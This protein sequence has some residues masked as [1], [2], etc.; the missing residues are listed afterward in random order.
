MVMESV[1]LT[2]Y[3]EEDRANLTAKLRE[4]RRILDIL[5]QKRSEAQVEL[6]NLA[7]KALEVGAAP[8]LIEE[9]S[10]LDAG[11]L[12]IEFARLPDQDDT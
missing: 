6:R 12:A 3:D 9:I 7:L 5:E 4:V 10:G 1:E 11:V 8:D 2:G